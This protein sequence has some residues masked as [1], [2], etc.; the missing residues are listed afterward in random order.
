[1]TQM[2]ELSDR[3]HR[4][5]MVNM[6]KSLLEKSSVHEQIGNIIEEMENMKNNK[7]EMLQMEKW[8]NKKDEC[9]P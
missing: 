5:T 1:M 4:I 8:E 9:L 7:V 3:E 2:L 6:L